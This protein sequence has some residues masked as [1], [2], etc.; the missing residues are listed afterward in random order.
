[1]VRYR[2]Y[3]YVIVGGDFHSEGGAWRSI[4]RFYKQQEEAGESCLLVDLRRGDGLRQWLMALLYSP[5]VIVNALAALSRWSVLIPLLFRKDVALYLHDTEHSLDAFQRGNPW[6]Y[7]LLAHLLK[8][9]HVLCVSESMASL[10]RHRFGTT[11]TTVVYEVV[12]V[13]PRPR[14]NPERTHIIMVGTLNRRKGYPL[15]C[16]VAKLAKERNLP[17]QFHWVGG[18][19]ESDLAPV[20]SAMTWWGW[21]DSAGPILEQCDVLFLSSEDDPQPLAC[22]EA[23]ALGKRAVGF[24]ATGSSEIL[25]QLSGCRVFQHFTPESALTALQEALAESVDPEAHAK[26]LRSH[27]SSDAMEQRFAK[28]WGA[29]AKLR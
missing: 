20:D 10:Y 27:C 28:I 5:R 14:L 29:E 7:K 26:I 6:R 4:Y 19:G 8:T 22:L 1:M 16:D 23:L 9:H 13:E 3:S 21:R 25:S 2:N 11:R 17:W 24:A 18:L 12:D 15:F